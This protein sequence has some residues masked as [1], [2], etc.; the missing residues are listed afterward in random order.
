MHVILW[1]IAGRIHTIRSFNIKIQ[2]KNY[3]YH[4]GVKGNEKTGVVVLQIKRK[5]M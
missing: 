1:T 3:V 4:V 2:H 5:L